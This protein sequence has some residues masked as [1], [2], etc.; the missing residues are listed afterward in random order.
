M[1]KITRI[2]KKRIINVINT[3]DEK[4]K[5]YFPMSSMTKEFA[6]DQVDN[7]VDSLISCLKKEKDKEYIIKDNNIVPVD[8]EN[9]GVIQNLVSWSH[10]L[11]QFLQM[12]HNLP[13]TPITI[14]TNYLSNLGFFKRYIKSKGNFIFGMTG[15]LGS[16]KARELLANVYSL[17]FDFIPPNSQRIL[18]E[19]TSCICFDNS[20][21]IKNIKRIVK[22]ETDGGR[23]IL[24]I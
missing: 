24:I 12:K 16:K 9:T 18:T 1:S 22:R 4:S 14:I 10:G 15:T 19:L 3:K 5:F 13:V 17:D 11:H 6:L 7:W 2:F 20:N 8:Q 21:F 23:A